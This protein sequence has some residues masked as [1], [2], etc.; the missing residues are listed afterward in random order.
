MSDSSSD[1]DNSSTMA[2]PTGDASGYESVETTV[3]EGEMNKR[4][5][6]RVA[7]LSAELAKERKKALRAQKQLEKPKENTI[8][9][10]KSTS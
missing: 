4:L 10:R 7:S 9:K 3:S 2:E 5:Q 8:P 6:Q 1:D